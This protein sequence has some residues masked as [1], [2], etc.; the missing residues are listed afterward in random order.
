MKRT[1]YLLLLFLTLFVTSCS[2][3]S[4]VM[5]SRRGSLGKDIEPMKTLKVD[6]DAYV[7]GWQLEVNDGINRNWP[8]RKLV[9]Q[10]SR[11][12]KSN[13]TELESDNAQAADDILESNTPQR[14]IIGYYATTDSKTG[15][16]VTTPVYEDEKI[17][18]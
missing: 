14:K 7:I 11:D 16:A 4:E 18:E 5:P 13:L 8:N 2:D 9:K 17:V 1:G 10:E 15:R 12:S 6:G 3:T